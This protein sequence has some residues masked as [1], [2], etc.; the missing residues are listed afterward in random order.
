MNH[1]IDE[2]K[3]PSEFL[4]N[5]LI[6]DSLEEKGVYSNKER[7]IVIFINKEEKDVLENASNKNIYIVENEE[8]AYSLLD[9]FKSNVE[10]MENVL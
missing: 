4:E 8:E 9:F 6:V 2:G 10:L 5:F 7:R 3:Y 1:I